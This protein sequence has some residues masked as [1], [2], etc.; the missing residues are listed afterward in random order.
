LTHIC[1]NTQDIIDRIAGLE[2]EG[3]L[4]RR[5]VVVPRARVAHMLQRALI[6]QD[7]V[8]V[9]AGTRFVTVK[10]LAV[11][12]LRAA[13][14]R[15]REGENELRPS[16]LQVLFRGGLDPEY[17]RRSLVQ[18]APGW[19][20]ALARTV[21]E[22]ERAG[23]NAADLQ[24]VTTPAGRGLATVWA[25]LD[26]T[27]GV[28]MTR[29]GMVA[30][31]AKVLEHQPHVAAGWGAVLAL[32]TGYVDGVEARL[33][34]AIPRV[35]V[36]LRAARPLR[37]GFADRV[38][39]LFGV[40]ARGALEAEEPPLQGE[41]D[42]QVF[43]RYL[44]EP[45]EVQS[46]P[47]RTRAGAE[48]DGTVSLEEHA[49]ACAEIEAAADWVVQQVVERQTPLEEIALLVP[50]LD[51][52]AQLVAD[53]LQQ[54]PWAGG[55]PVHVAG[56]RALTSS[57]AGGR[58]LAVL[59]A[60]RGHL[61]A[62][63]VA[64][65]LPLLGT[66]DQPIAHGA[67]MDLAHALGT[68]GGSAAHP[69]GAMAWPERAASRESALAAQV[70][71]AEETDG[72]EEQA[73]HA[74]GV[75]EKER[76]LRDLQIVRPGLE[77]LVGVAEAL[78]EIRPLTEVWPLLATFLRKRVLVGE[79]DEEALG[80]LDHA[81]DEACRDASCGTLSGS[82]ALGLI[83]TTL[84][85]LRAPVGRF[86]E[87]AV[88]VGTVSG[89]V[90]L[91]FEAVR[92]MGLVDGTIPASPR[93]DTV[94]PDDVRERIGQGRA[95][96]ASDVALRSLQE[97]YQVVADT[98]GKLVLSTPR[99]GLDR[100]YREPSSVFLEA[101][102][103]LGRPPRDGSSDR[104]VPDLEE[105]RQRE[106]ARSQARARAFRERHPIGEAAWHDRVA[107]DRREGRAPAV[108]SQWLDERELDL[109]RIAAL[110]DKADWS[111][112]DGI[113]GADADGP[114][115]PGLTPRRPLSASRWRTFLS[116][117]H[118]F[119]Y[120]HLLGW[121][122]PATRRPH[123]ELDALA[124]GSLFHR[125]LECFF[126]S[127]GAQFWS[128]QEPL[129]AWQQDAQGTAEREF[130]LVL[131]QY[132]L[133]GEAVQRQQL[134]RL[135]GEVREFVQYLWELG[136]SRFAATERPF[137]Y[138]EPVALPSEAKQVFV[139]GYIDLIDVVGN[140]TRIWDVKTGKCHLRRGSDADPVPTLDAQLAL[141][142]LVARQLADQ[143]GV[144]DLQAAYAHTNDRRGRIR[145]FADDFEELETA[146]R[147]WLSVTAQLMADRSFPRTPSSE[148]C[149]Y[150]PFLPVCGPKATVR[151]GR[152]LAAAGD[153][154]RDGG[155]AL[156][157]FARVRS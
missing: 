49:G 104:E 113:L 156:A 44:F 130:G 15:F 135:R 32:A 119:L 136:P 94:L 29:A 82:D 106:F 69:Q 71:G 73:G 139:R 122:E 63:L 114:L 17:F 116:C 28:S 85:S 13:D 140:T 109:V 35:E 4:P 60:L 100:S 48:P 124:Y 30:R 125:V 134:D 62:D 143:W 95:T 87:A 39:A 5:T 153:D 126:R 65:I 90:G 8:E 81:V 40:G 77:Q 118:R 96:V 53:R 154:V 88:Y 107:G 23:L 150:C 93:E 111:A 3:P 105:I 46:H 22:L 70:A 58:M 21:G 66:A 83:E 68:V 9:L 78:L 79:D 147:W 12:V 131:E 110:Q 144:E 127:G 112:M 45:P 91:E 26:Q 20:H 64:A 155:V 10:A 33:I 146:G 138:A 117:P 16:R 27:A 97:L 129:S 25:A 108:P 19:E 102:T 137:G 99:L 80:L 148:D 47:Q 89:A 57:S 75:R 24:Q 6:Q 61:G 84:R 41:I 120:E 43:V 18:S 152:L 123:G 38:E 132:P 51:P 34:Q 98:G 101:A 103:A 145:A 133:E 54:L 67:A 56:G 11:E 55:F 36:A 72:D 121:A 1:W 14:V 52:M 128:R 37:A 76:L 86:G 115:L 59:E 92:V 50:Q 42:L 149:T 7:R 141:Y 151:S 74:R 2:G 142:G 157:E 31:A